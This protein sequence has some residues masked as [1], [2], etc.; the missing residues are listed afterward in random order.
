MKTATLFHYSW[1]NAALNPTQGQYPYYLD[2]L[3]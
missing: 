3:A 1:E 2:Y